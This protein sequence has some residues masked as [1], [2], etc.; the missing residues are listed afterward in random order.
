[1]NAP[2]AVA[3]APPVR[4]N[5]ALHIV[6]QMMRGAVAGK[7][8]GVLREVCTAT[9]LGVSALAD[10]FRAAAVAV[11]VPVMML[12]NNVLP[13]VMIPQFKEWE[14][15]GRAP[16][17]L[18]SLLAVLF[19]A[20]SA[21][22][23]LLF[24]SADLWVGLIVPGFDAATRAQTEA[25][26]RVMLLATPMFLITT[27]ILCAEVAI[28]RCRSGPMQQ[29]FSNASVIIGLLLFAVTGEPLVIGWCFACAF[30]SLAL[31]GLRHLYGLGMIDLEGARIGPGV[32]AICQLA[33]RGG[34]LFLQPVVIGV[35]LIV[36]RIVASELAT[37]AVAA[38]DYARAISATSVILIGVPVGMAVLAQ[39]YHQNPAKARAHFR[40]I[41]LFSLA[42]GVPGAV[43]LVLRAPDIVAV[44]LERGVFQADATLVTATI[45]VGFGFGFWSELL[46][47]LLVKMLN[48]QGRNNVAMLAVGVGF[49]LQILF[50]FVAV[51][52]VGLLGLGLA[53]ALRAIVTMIL[54][55]LLL[56][57]ARELLALVLRFV[58]LGVISAAL[59]IAVEPMP[60]S[61]LKLVVVGGTLTPSVVLY[62]LAVST[63]ARTLARHYG[64]TLVAR[65]APRWRRTAA[66]EGGSS[67]RRT[68]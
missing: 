13:A 6:W 24:V 63:E 53:T 9:V 39:D 68:P 10:S 33:R 27:A 62:T 14:A 15:S 30:V 4:R 19:V 48:A 57:F 12:T 67:K 3:P 32:R 52:V 22:A 5:S 38:L 60:Q 45:L 51:P 8:L 59:S 65:V 64:G 66:G 46:N 43:V 35:T 58:P 42:V 41:A 56:G 44:L 40:R 61:W 20:S 18:T 21:V 2:T 23:G 36:E 7:L 28:G 26:V 1:M 17:I 29:V 16:A 47:D 25:F 34:L 49:A 55:A 11:T 31:Y 50:L 54:S 37:G